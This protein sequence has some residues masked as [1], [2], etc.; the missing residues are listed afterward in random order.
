[1]EMREL[2]EKL[3]DLLGEKMREKLPVYIA[4]DG[5]EAVSYL[6]KKIAKEVKIASSTLA[7]GLTPSFVTSSQLWRVLYNKGRGFKSQK[8]A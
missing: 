8:G 2:Q 3:R 1:M 4:K 5:E 6:K 7:K